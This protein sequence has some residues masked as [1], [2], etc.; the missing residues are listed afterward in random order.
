MSHLIYT[1]ISLQSQFCYSSICTQRSGHIKIFSFTWTCHAPAP[2]T[3]SFTCCYFCMKHS[4]ISLRSLI[5]TDHSVSAQSLLVPKVFFFFSE[6]LKSGF[7]F[8]TKQNKLISNHERNE[9]DD[10]MG[11]RLTEMGY[12]GKGFSVQRG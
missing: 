9:Q 3:G 6:F 1:L 8:L 5:L 11:S 12:M 4:S 10:V 2:F 7:C